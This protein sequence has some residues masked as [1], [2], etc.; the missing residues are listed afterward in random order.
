MSAITWFFFIY[1]TITEVKNIISIISFKMYQGLSYTEV[2]YIKVP[3]CYHLQ[4]KNKSK[5]LTVTGIVSL[6]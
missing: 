6:I 4:K 2:H 3:P 5:K 1:F